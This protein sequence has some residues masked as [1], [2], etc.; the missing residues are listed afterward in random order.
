[1][2]DRL[3]TYHSTSLKAAHLARFDHGELHESVLSLTLSY[4]SNYNMIFPPINDVLM[5]LQYVRELG[6]PVE[7]ISIARRIPPIVNLSYEFPLGKSRLRLIHHPEILLI[8]TVVFTAMQYFPL[9][10]TPMLQDNNYFLVPNFQWEEWQDV[11]A[12]ALANEPTTLTHD[13]L[14]VTA[15]QITSMEPADLDEYFTQ[16]SLSNDAQSE[17]IML[18]KY[19]PSDQLPSSKPLFEDLENNT[20]ERLCRIQAQATSF[21]S[22]TYQKRQ[23]DTN[24][25]KAMNYSYKSEED[26]P[27]AGKDFFQLAARLAGLSVPMLMRAVNMLETHIVAWQREQRRAASE[28]RERSSTSM[29]MD[30]IGEQSSQIV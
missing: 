5:T 24:I 10:S 17:D 9:E 14:S 18:A 15:S 26:L 6:L 23:G 4:N 20:V 3:P 30:P 2:R 1:M 29:S 19:F 25:P 7:T 22:S 27:Q 13:Y 11:M 21:V 28:R 12:P 16:L 8:A